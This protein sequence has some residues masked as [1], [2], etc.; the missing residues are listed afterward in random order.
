MRTNFCEKI[1]KV[2]WVLQ[3]LIFAKKPTSDILQEL[4][5]V[6]FTKKIVYLLPYFFIWN[7]KSAY[8]DSQR[9]NFHFSFFGESNF[10]NFAN[11]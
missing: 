8:K 1:F 11:W 6:P 9:H 5:L 10:A 4:N 3:E 2:F 7:E